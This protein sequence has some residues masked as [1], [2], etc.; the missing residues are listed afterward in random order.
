MEDESVIDITEAPVSD[1]KKQR[2]I[3]IATELR[4]INESYAFT[5]Y[6][7][8]AV[9]LKLDTPPV[10]YLKIETFYSLMA[11]N[12]FYLGGM[13]K[14]VKLGP[15][16]MAWGSRRSYDDV[17]FYP[18]DTSDRNVYNLWRGFA[19]E[20]IE[21]D[22][23][24][25]LDHMRV[26]ICAGNEANYNWL[27]D[28]MA[29]AVQKP[30][31]KNWTAVLLE[32]PEEGTGKGFFVSQ[33]GKLFGPHFGAF[34]KP[35]QLLGKFNSHLE[36]KL[37]LFLDEG[38]LVEKYAYDFA[39]SLI[40]EPTLNIEPK[41]R[42]MREVNSYHRV[43]MAS[44]DRHILRSTI[45]DRRWMVLRV[46]ALCQNNLGYFNAIA[47]QMR[48]GGY[49]ALMHLLVNRKY[50]EDTIKLTI[51][52]EA[53]NDQKDHNLPD[54]VRWWRSCLTMKRIGEEEWP[55]SVHTKYFYKA[56]IHWCEE[57]KINKR[58]SEDWLPRRLNADVGT[59]LKSYNKCYE[60]P[61]ID[62]A[63]SNLEDKLGYVINWN[64]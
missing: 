36:D 26:N 53:L 15:A 1:P 64:D 49:N 11:N 41:G 6:G 63:R 55:L 13:E 29:D 22:C 33:F 31:R 3:K 50:N 59:S 52:T 48:C 14:P 24:L 40:T 25:Y 5:M 21:G 42:S 8:T 51:K 20:P 34:N 47:D 35:S 28:W 39:K 56:Y 16:W 10:K 18:G 60:L 7:D 27:L 23:S 43:I 54:H 45:H 12:L 38:S 32:S 37:M 19:Y 62:P 4:K 17:V 57:M 30:W 46:S 44:N 9:I 2:G 61:D 58:E